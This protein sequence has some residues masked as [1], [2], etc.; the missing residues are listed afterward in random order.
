MWKKDEVE[1]VEYLEKAAIKKHFEI[2]QYFC[3]LDEYI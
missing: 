3:H 2:D 1:K